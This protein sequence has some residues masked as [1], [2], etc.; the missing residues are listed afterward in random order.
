VPV[1]HC[2]LMVLVE[3]RLASMTPCDPKSRSEAD[4]S[5]HSVV[6]VIL[7]AKLPVAVAAKAGF[8]RQSKQQNLLQQHLVPKC[9]NSFILLKMTALAATVSS[10][11]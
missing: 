5:L 2:T 6:I 11:L 8:V 4:T 3:S 10:P 7:T 9:Q 1:V